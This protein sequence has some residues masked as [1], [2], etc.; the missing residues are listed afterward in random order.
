MVFQISKGFVEG[1]LHAREGRS[2]LMGGAL[3]GDGLVMVGVGSGQDTIRIRHMGN[4]EIQGPK[5]TPRLDF[6][7]FGPEAVKGVVRYGHG[8]LVFS[9]CCIALY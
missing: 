7:Q 6:V 4:G 1:G 3:G 5:R 9:G 2:V 8:I